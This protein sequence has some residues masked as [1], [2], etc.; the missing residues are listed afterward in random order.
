MP[1]GLVAVGERP[2]ADPS[3]FHS[4]NPSDSKASYLMFLADRFPASR[5]GRR[6]DFRIKKRDG[7][8]TEKVR[9]NCNEL[10]I[11]A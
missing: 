7:V 1:S 5:R 3:T 2:K 10:Q 11:R 8:N 9:R 4:P 6:R